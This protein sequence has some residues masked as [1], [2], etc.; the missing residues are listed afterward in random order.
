VVDKVEPGLRQESTDASEPTRTALTY[1]QAL[2]LA[3]FGLAALNT[4]TIVLSGEASLIV[5]AQLALFDVG[6]ELAI[7]IVGYWLLTRLELRLR[8][9]L[10]GL[11]AL[12]VLA[13]WAWI[14]PDFASFCDRHGHPELRI[15]LG[16]AAALSVPM[17]AAVGQ[18]CR[19]TL[20]RTLAVSVALL[21]AALNHHVL[22]AD[23]PGIHLL[24]AWNALALAV[25]ALARARPPRLLASTIGQLGTERRAAIA[26]A[27]GLP[28]AL[29]SLIV[30]PPTPVLVEVF[31]SEGSVLFPFVVALHDEQHPSAS[32]GLPRQLG[33][34]TAYLERRA[35]LPEIAASQP[36]LAPREP[37]VI[38]VT[39]DAV[40]AELLNKG[41]WRRRL[42][43]LAALADGSVEFTQARSAGSTT[44]NSLGQLFSSRYAS[45]LRWGKAG[46]FAH[47]HDDPTPRLTDRLRQAGFSTL[48]LPPLPT[49]ASQHAVVGR[50]EHEKRLSSVSKGQRFPLSSAA[51]KEALKL[52]KKHASGPTFLYMHWLDAHDP[53]D[54]AGEEGST[55]ERYLRE[56]ELADRS[57]GELIKGLE[58]RGLWERTILIVSADHG[59]ALG[60]HGIPHHGGGIY[61]SLVRVPLV[62]RVPGVR[63]RRVDVPVTTLDIAPT[64]LDLVGQPTPGEYMGQ[65][66]VGFLRGKQR[67]GD[68]FRRNEEPLRLASRREG[69]AAGRPAPCLLRGQ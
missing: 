32:A 37:L 29:L 42:P 46:R 44:R 27:L 67:S 60:D 28:L 26:S 25:A 39:I 57:L 24:L 4:A 11:T 9:A 14:A 34:D 47:L 63:A 6:H 5:R 40:R 12:A 1:A 10:G 2:L 13:G 49:L 68:G 50:F 30:L 62:M 22:Q 17:A 69:P 56:V 43:R 41:E 54:A 45:Q 65:S 8:V 23:Y 48:N 31:R 38:L 61:E 53:Y 51:V 21:V 20:L 15:P 55:F 16:I 59:E 64:L 18:L 66:L 33:I 3:C 36:S 58:Q 52:L 7:A 35:G 19:T